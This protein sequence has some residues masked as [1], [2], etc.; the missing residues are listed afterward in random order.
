MAGIYLNCAVSGIIFRPISFLEN[1][2]VPEVKTL[3]KTDVP[4]PLIAIPVATARLL[5]K[6][7]PTATMAVMNVIPIPMPRIKKEPF[8]SVKK[9]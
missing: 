6:Y 7:R 5:L 1:S 8:C 3:E 9:E 2:S 4:A